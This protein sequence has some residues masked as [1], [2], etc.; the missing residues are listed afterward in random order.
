MLLFRLQRGSTVMAFDGGA[1]HLGINNTVLVVGLNSVA[2][3]R[4]WNSLAA[5]HLVFWFSLT[6]H[7]LT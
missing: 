3:M 1:H 2:F 6:W 7:S 5:Q 4:S